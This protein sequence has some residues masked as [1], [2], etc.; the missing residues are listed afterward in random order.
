MI[1]LISFCLYLFFLL[2]LTISLSLSVTKIGFRNAANLTLS[3]VFI[4][5]AAILIL[6]SPIVLDSD[7]YRY[8]IYFMYIKNISFSLENDVGFYFLTRGISYLTNE[9]WVYHLSILTLQ[10]IFI[11]MACRNIDL[12]LAKYALFILLVTTPFFYSFQ[13][14]IVRS[15]LATCISLYAISLLLIG[16]NNKFFLFSILAI[17]V[18][19]SSLLMLVFFILP[20]YFEKT[21]NLKVLLNTWLFLTFLSVFNFFPLEFMKVYLSGVDRVS[22]YFV[23]GGVR[24]D[25]ITTGFKIQ[26]FVFTCAPLILITILFGRN[27]LEDIFVKYYL[28]V[29]IVYTLFSFM[30]YSDR[31]I[32]FGWC[33]YPILILRVSNIVNETKSYIF[34]VLYIVIINSIYFISL[35]KA[36]M[37]GLS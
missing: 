14:N 28:I 1:L 9:F 26:F 18:H 11:Y 31:I 4:L 15:G 10:Y 32:Y 35:T 23:D 37:R 25:N 27:Y 6:K 34:V 5:I 30:P 20:K 36:T 24:L 13:T 17:S 21:L 12:G 33:I 3:S 22:G 2:T 19:V 7:L 8:N 16:K 29:T